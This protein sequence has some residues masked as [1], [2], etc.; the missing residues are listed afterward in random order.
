MIFPCLFFFLGEDHQDSGRSFHFPGLQVKDTLWKN[1]IPLGWRD[2]RGLTDPSHQTP[3]GTWISCATSVWRYKRGWFLVVN[4]CI[5]LPK[6]CWWIGGW[7][8]QKYI[9]C[10][11]PSYPLPLNTPELGS[12]RSGRLTAGD[13]SCCNPL[14]KGWDRKGLNFTNTSPCFPGYCLSSF[15]Y[16]YYTHIIWL[17]SSWDQHQPLYKQVSDPFCT[18][19]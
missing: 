10:R 15:S 19:T 13:G 2:S 11:V 9:C 4:F 7:R 17:S 8:Q 14:E 6:S 12:S 1:Q 16:C 5:F 18:E 3:P